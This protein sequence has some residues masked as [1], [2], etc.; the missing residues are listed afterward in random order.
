VLVSGS[1]GRLTGGRFTP[2]ALPF[3]EMTMS[4]VFLTHN[5]PRWPGDVAGAFLATLAAALVR[6]GIAVTVVV[7]SDGGNGGDET[8]ANGVRVRRVRYAAAGDERFAYGAMASALASPAGIGA[9]MRMWRAL[10]VAARHEVRQGA[11][12]VHAHWWFPSGLAAPRGVPLV[13]TSHGSDAALLARS[14]PARALARPVYRRAAVVTAVSSELARW[15]AAGTGR[16]LRPTD[17]QPMPVDTGRFTPSRGGGGGGGGGGGAIVVSRLVP[18]K[19]VHLAIETVA[20][21][22]DRGAALPLTVVG[23]GPER[24][25]LER[26]AAERGVAPLVRFVGAVPPDDVPR[27]LATADVM[28]FPAFREGFGLV[29]AEAFLSAVPVVACCDGGGVLDIVPETGAGR[30]VAPAADA[31]AAAALELLRSSDKTDDLHRLREFWCRRLNADSVAE[32]CERWY[33]DALASHPR[34][35]V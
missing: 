28:L 9:I 8:S 16:K 14:W 32:V 17:I 18:Q 21:L 35:A 33:R 22:R 31:M 12:V 3:A 26:L 15:I 4:V 29:A 30:R 6:R 23:D 1:G 11:A 27:Y 34:Q 7:P 13:V 24:G 20:E 25:A 10:R 2:I 5:Y 19:R